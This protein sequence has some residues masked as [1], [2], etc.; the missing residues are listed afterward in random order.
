VTLSAYTLFG[1][2]YIA[3]MTFIVAYLKAGG[4]E[5]GTIAAFWAVL[6]LAAIV[7]GF[8]WGPMLGRLR[9][10]RGVAVLMAVV[11]VGALLPLITHATSI[12]F[13]SALLFG[14]SF[15]SVVTAVTTVARTALRP[16]QWTAA[17]A[18]LTTG[19]AIGQCVGPIL[20]GVLADGTDGV[21]SGLL[22]SVLILAVGA[23]TSLAQPAHTP[24][25]HPNRIVEP[26]SP[27]S[28]GQ[29]Q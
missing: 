2:G 12:A 20:A 7:G 14:I 19:F 15:L 3:Y 1:A 16:D 13:L 27:T 24:P 5:A 10:G 8:V 18:A 11:T 26:I 23:L 28:G 6:G 21:R 29:P 4:A 22:V 17:I 9:G 25:E